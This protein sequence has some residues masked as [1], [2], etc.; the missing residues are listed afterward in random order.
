MRNKQ[1]VFAGDGEDALTRTEADGLGAGGEHGVLV[2]DSHSRGDLV[3][4]DLAVHLGCNCVGEDEPV[5]ATG[6]SGARSP[7]P[8]GGGTGRFSDAN[9][10]HA[11]KTNLLTSNH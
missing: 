11:V 1:S 9:G 5:Q 7:P 10:W 8:A 4:G 6:H 3:R 2:G